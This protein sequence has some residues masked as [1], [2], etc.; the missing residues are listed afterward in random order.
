MIEQQ[1]PAFRLT[2]QEKQCYFFRLTYQHNSKWTFSSVPTCIPCRVHNK[3]CSIKDVWWADPY[4]NDGY[5]W[6]QIA[7][8]QSDRLCPIYQCCRMCID[9]CANIWRTTHEHWWSNIC[10]K[11]WRP[12]EATSDSA[13]CNL[14]VCLNLDIVHFLFGIHLK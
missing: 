2:T 1:V 12:C 3:S 4:W 13:L 8:V 9:V 6:C 7:V 10:G 11:I 5:L 14:E